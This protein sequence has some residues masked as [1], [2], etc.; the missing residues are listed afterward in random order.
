[1]SGVT[2]GDEDIE[3]PVAPVRG[4]PRILLFYISRSGS[5]NAKARYDGKRHKPGAFGLVWPVAGQLYWKD[6]WPAAEGA[7]GSDDGETNEFE[8]M[9][10]RQFLDYWKS[11]QRMWRPV[12]CDADWVALLTPGP[13]GR[14]GIEPFLEG[15][16][17]A[18]TEKLGWSCTPSMV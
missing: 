8:T 15:V 16:R 2:S 7:L 12:N 11:L 6:L 13:D 10:Q 17:S 3:W 14:F 9:L 5:P 4:H 1:M 18:A